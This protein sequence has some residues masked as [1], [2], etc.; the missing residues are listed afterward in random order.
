MLQRSVLMAK[1]IKKLVEKRNLR[2]NNMSLKRSPPDIPRNP[3]PDYWLSPWGQL[4]TR[5]ASVVGG[6][7]IGSR[8]GKLFRRRFRVPY[9]VFCKLVS[10]SLDK[11]LF[12]LN[13]HKKTDI[14][15][16]NVCPVKM[17]LLAVLRILGRNWNFDDIAEA[18]LMGETTARRAFH[19]FSQNFF[20]EYY[21]LY[22]FRPQGEKLVKVMQVFAQMGLPGCI[23]STDCVHL[24]WDRCPIDIAQLCSGK[25]GYPTLAYSCTVD[26]HRRILGST[27]SYWGAKND[28]TIV[29]G[30]TYITDVKFK[31]VHADTH[32]DI[33]VNG[34]IKS[35]TGVYYL[36]DGG[37]HKWTC[38]MNP[39][40][41]TSTRSDRLWSEWVESTRKDVEC[42]FGILKSRWRF[43]LNGIVLQD[44]NYLDNAFFTCCILH[45]LILEYDGLDSRWE[46]LHPQPNNSDEGFDEND[47]PVQS[48]QQTLIN[49]RVRLWM[50]SR[51]NSPEEEI[52]LGN[53]FE[54]EIDVDFNTKRRSLID[55]F[56]YAYNLGLV[57]WP[58]CLPPEKRKIYNK[59]K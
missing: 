14:A 7:S 58:S 22:V 6:P 43:L 47:E 24:K 21:H 50:S 38:M 51:E 42:T 19:T 4:L 17:K 39:L 13:S 37:Y 32:F 36:C 16:R 20:K 12:G 53:D 9:D 49:A 5:F 30:D 28:K 27:S 41:H 1:I 18:T 33:F 25:E 48:A 26:H 52:V 23:G 59:G 35:V 40:K 56:I 31:R 29:R 54:E 3:N 34:S 10:M 57:K 44:Q 11:K 15:N 55:H 2:H 8:E 45:N 46:T